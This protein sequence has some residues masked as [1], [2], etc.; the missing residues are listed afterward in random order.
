M[1]QNEKVG[2]SKSKLLNEISR[3]IIDFMAKNQPEKPENLEDINVSIYLNVIDHNVGQG[4]E[5]IFGNISL[6]V[7]DIM[8]NENLNKLIILKMLVDG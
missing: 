7:E 3:L 6:L 5:M 4:A 1:L 2:D 8:E